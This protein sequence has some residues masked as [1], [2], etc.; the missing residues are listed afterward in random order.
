[1]SITNTVVSQ[2]YVANGVQVLF[3]IPFDYQVE[4]EVTVYKDG[5][6]KT[7]VA[8]YTLTD[9]SGNPTTVNEATH[10][11]FGLAPASLVVV[12]VA[13]STEL[14]QELDFLNSDPSSLELVEEGLDKITQIAQ[15]LASDLANL[16]STSDLAA[17]LSDISDL[18]SDVS[19]LQLAVT[20]LQNADIVLTNALGD[21]VS[22]LA[23]TQADLDTAESEIDNL[24]TAVGNQSTAILNIG[25][26]I[27]AINLAA[28]ALDLRVS[29][30]ESYFG[31]AGE[32]AI[33]NN[34]TANIVGMLFNMATYDAVIIDF[35]IFR[36]TDS[37]NKYSSGQI[38][39]VYS[40]AI[41]SWRIEKISEA[42][43]YSGVT[44]AVTALGQVS[45]TSSDITGVNYTGKMKYSIKKFEV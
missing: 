23:D 5:V 31:G 42:L 37:N 43:D 29:A 41:N 4:D 21:A 18:E 35:A 2:D 14:T 12:T 30:L 19:A 32:V 39:V 9:S 34:D 3:S 17:I 27:S 10:V 33:L 11:K 15:E 8:D 22:D 13:R 16:V 38:A 6:L 1:M 7:V 26:Q 45:Y 36:K 28:A 44:F 20:S 40:A 24:Q 25:T